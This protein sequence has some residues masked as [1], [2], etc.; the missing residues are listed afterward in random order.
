[1]TSFTDWGTTKPLGKVNELSN[2]HYA[3]LLD[4]TSS[5]PQFLH[6]P[7]VLLQ[8]RE[9][10]LLERLEKGDKEIYKTTEFGQEI[11]KRYITLDSLKRAPETLQEIKNDLMRQVHRKK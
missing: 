3:A 5:K 8:L 9:A 10:G 6:A 7:M 1:M 2:S 4:Y 11:I